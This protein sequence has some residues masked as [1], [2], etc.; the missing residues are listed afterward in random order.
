[1]SVEH[2]TPD[3]HLLAEEMQKRV[4]E[5]RRNHRGYTYLNPQVTIRCSRL[6]SAFLRLARTHQFRWCR[7]FGQSFP[8]RVLR[9]AKHWVCGGWHEGDRIKR[10][11]DRAFCFTGVLISNGQLTLSPTLPHPPLRRR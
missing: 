11:R 9:Q 5:E 3:F 1:M 6:T 7:R 8:R 2:Y 10:F 4:S